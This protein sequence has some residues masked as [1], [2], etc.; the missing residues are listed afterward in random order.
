MLYKFSLRFDW[1]DPE[2]EVWSTKIRYGMRTEF[3]MNRDV[4]D[5]YEIYQ[6]ILGAKESMRRLDEMLVKQHFEL[7]N[8]L[9]KD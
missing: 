4:T 2:G 6:L 3:E 9:K 7:Q 5:S 8:S 1:K